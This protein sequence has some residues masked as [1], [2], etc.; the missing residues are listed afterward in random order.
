[1]KLT[2]KELEETIDGMTALCADAKKQVK[3][4]MFKVHGFE[5]EEDFPIP[6]LGTVWEFPDE[7]FTC[8]V[9]PTNRSYI[10]IS[11][12]GMTH[13]AGGQT[14]TQLVSILKKNKAVKLADSPEEYWKGKK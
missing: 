10:L 13:W 9:S 3:T 7:D 6:K 12:D 5:V 14:G 11:V 2:Q 4:L 1:M 8:V